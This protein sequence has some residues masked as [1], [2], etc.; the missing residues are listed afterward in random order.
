[1]TA[2]GAIFHICPEGSNFSTK[3]KGIVKNMA[4]TSVHI[5]TV[6]DISTKNPL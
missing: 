3:S 4:I 5:Q 6:D 1:V 2:S